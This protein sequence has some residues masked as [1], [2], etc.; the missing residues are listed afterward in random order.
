MWDE[1]ISC[2]K[3]CSCRLEHFTELA[4]H[5]FMTETKPDIIDET[6]N[7][8]SNDVRITNNIYNINTI[9]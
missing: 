6:Q 4:I 9:R 7:L 5:R 1:H 2:P 3:I 8:I